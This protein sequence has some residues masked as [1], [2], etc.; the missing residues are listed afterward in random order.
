V[1]SMG[2]NKLFNKY[3][4]MVSPCSYPGL[5]TLLLSRNVSWKCEDTAILQARR[6]NQILPTYLTQP[7]IMNKEFRIF[8]ND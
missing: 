2:Y 3:K 7:Y 6:G 1:K 4:N 5:I 8:I